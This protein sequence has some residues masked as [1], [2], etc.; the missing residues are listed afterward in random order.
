MIG[1]LGGVLLYTLLPVAAVLLG[2]GVAIFKAPGPRLSSG[3]QHFAA[4][5]VFA[6]VA[7]ELLPEVM[8]AH[9]PIPAMLGFA[10]GVAALLAVRWFAEQMQ[11]QS[12][13]KQAQPTSMLAVIGIDVFIDGILVGVGFAA[14]QEQGILLT[15]ALTL[16]VLFLGLSTSAELS[17]AG[18]AR[19]RVLGMVMLLAL[20]LAIGAGLGVTLLRGLTGAALEAA[21][22]FGAAAL[23]YLVTEELLVEAHEVPETPLTTATFFLGF[24]ILFV[25]EMV[26]TTPSPGGG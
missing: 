23:L 8:R 6:A 26:A 20:L 14:G 10:I 7:V 13:Q 19:G 21:L 12:V 9:A 17:E 3:I 15:I 4:G 2:G 25:I 18:A 5:V 1:S 16:E 22:A 11:A 24:L